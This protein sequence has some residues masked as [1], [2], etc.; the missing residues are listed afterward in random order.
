MISGF[1]RAL[2]ISIIK[3]RMKPVIFSVLLLLIT[4]PVTVYAEEPL[5]PDGFIK[6]TEDLL[7]ML[8]ALED[9]ARNSNFNQLDNPVI[10]KKFYT[11][12][13]SLKKYEN[14]S[15]GTV[16]SWPEGQQKK[17]ASEVYSVN[18]L[19]RAYSL[20]QHDEFRLK[21]EKS[22]IKVQELFHDYIS[23]SKTGKIGYIDN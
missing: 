10:Q 21:A 15:T 16:N 13:A 7:N 1:C 5:P 9:D 20:T 4:F 11:V 23:H 14:L 3:D 12:S 6:I 18:F 8:S 22:L 2:N 17:I 19:Y